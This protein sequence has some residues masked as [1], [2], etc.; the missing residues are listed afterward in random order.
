MFL[1]GLVANSVG[2]GTINL[3]HRVLSVAYNTAVRHGD[4]PRNPVLHAKK[5]RVQSVETKP[6]PR[7]DFI[8]IYQE[9][10]KDP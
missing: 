10:M 1:G 7:K 9:A 8:K 6:I 2:A 3:S 5:P 4:L